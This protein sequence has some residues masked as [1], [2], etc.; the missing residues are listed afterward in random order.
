[1][2]GTWRDWRYLWAYSLPLASFVGLMGLGWWTWLTPAYVFGLVP[3][4]EWLH[5]PTPAQTEPVSA[6][7]RRFAF[8]DWLLYLNAPLH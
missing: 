8:F 7:A 4:L 1:M 3:L 2:K 6:P 5:K